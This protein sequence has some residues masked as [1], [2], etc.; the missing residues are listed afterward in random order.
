LCTVLLA[1]IFTASGAH[2]AETG[3]AC[4]KADS[5]LAAKAFAPARK[6]YIDELSNAPGLQC[7]V[8]GLKKVADIEQRD[9]LSRVRLLESLGLYEEALTALKELAR[10]DPAVLT[11][12]PDDLQYLSGGKIGHWRALRR[13][14]EPTGRPLGEILAVLALLLFVFVWSYFRWFK[15][16]Y[17]EIEFDDSALKQE[18]GKGFTALMND[19]LKRLATGAPGLRLGLVTGPIAPVSIPAE[20]THAIPPAISWVNIVPALL[21][22]L[23][24][25]RLLSLSGQLHIPGELGAGVTLVLSESKNVISSLTIWQSQF[26]P[27][28]PPAVSVEPKAYYPLAE[29]AAIWL[30]FELAEHARA[31]V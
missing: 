5:L 13:Q 18:L 25:R 8:D 4:A 14:I 10:K 3:S 12:I 20:I 30:L 9:G 16:P 29:P 28:N 24:P 7:A 21:S 17:L 23:S 22:K 31:T 6:T 2:G 1:S 26:D 15:P 11:S 19:A 27:S